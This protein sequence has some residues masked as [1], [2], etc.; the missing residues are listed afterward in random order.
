M[1]TDWYYFK[2][3]QRIGPVSPQQLKGIASDGT[4]QPTDLVWKEG[5]SQA[6]RAEMIKGLYETTNRTSEP[7]PTHKAAESESPLRKRAETNNTLDWKQ[8]PLAVGLLLLC[9][10]PLGM[11]LVWT[12][13][14]WQQRTKWIITGC[15]IAFVLLGSLGSQ[16]DDQGRTSASSQSTPQSTGA[17]PQAV[18]HD[19]AIGKNRDDDTPTRDELIGLVYKTAAIASL[20]H[21][22]GTGPSPEEFIEL[23]HE[24]ARQLGAA[25]YDHSRFLLTLEP[26]R[27]VTKTVGKS[28]GRV[29]AYGDETV[30]FL[31]S[32]VTDRYIFLSC[33]IDGEDKMNTSG[34]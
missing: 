4:L 8:S 34:R 6:V 28:E 26:D 29:L 10:F 21:M 9:F 16:D 5:M 1:A 11:Y 7:S 25:N 13:P 14:M 15:Y 20:K 32:K 23:T 24:A 12:H 17:A 31:K 18:N 33:T 3:E 30:I 22:L 27:D 19:D 2:G